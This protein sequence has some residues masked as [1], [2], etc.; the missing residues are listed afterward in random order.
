VGYDELSADEVIAALS[1]RDDRREAVRSYEHAHKNRAAVRD[2]A[3][4][5]LT[6]V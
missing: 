1:E 5:T 4:R 3:A 6:S 2:A